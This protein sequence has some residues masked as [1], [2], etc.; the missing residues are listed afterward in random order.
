[1]LYVVKI[2]I[3]HD[4]NAHKLKYVIE[5]EKVYFLTECTVGLLRPLLLKISV[6]KGNWCSSLKNYYY[7]AAY[8][9]RK[10]P[11]AILR[12]APKASYI[13]VAQSSH[14]KNDG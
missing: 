13:H 4:P 10:Q 7:P 14:P 6:V 2:C 3:H 1:M 5:V 12:R 8:S 9:K 11:G